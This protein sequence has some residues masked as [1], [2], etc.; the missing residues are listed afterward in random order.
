METS[1]LLLG[2]TAFVVVLVA[3]L[4]GFYFWLS[5][6]EVRSIS[7]TDQS[8]HH[9]GRDVDDA[10]PTL[11]KGQKKLFKNLETRIRDL[12]HASATRAVVDRLASDLRLLKEQQ[13]DKQ[14][15]FRMENEIRKLGLAVASIEDG[16]TEFSAKRNQT[17]KN[18]PA[19]DTPGIYISTAERPE[20]RPLQSHLNDECPTPS[21]TR[22]PASAPLPIQPESIPTVRSQPAPRLPITQLIIREFDGIDGT[23]KRRLDRFKEEF[24]RLVGSELRDV[25][26]VD[27]AYL[28]ETATGDKYVHP[29]PNQ[30]LA[31]FWEKAFTAPSY[32]RPIAQVKTLAQVSDLTED[33]Y[34]VINK[35]SLDV[36]P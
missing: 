20:R 33:G 6:R 5:G 26:E 8:A 24:I 22:S 25:M 3:L 15:I 23:A 21:F 29:L 12:E 14:A 34:T 4:F 36:N 19:S 32:S 18:E 7:T 35:G 2:I 1:T 10:A 9:G 11:S 30:S 28:F 13:I 27:N 31:R 16:F 17:T